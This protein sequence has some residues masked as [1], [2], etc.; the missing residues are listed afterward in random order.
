MSKVDST[1]FS[2]FDNDECPRFTPFDERSQELSE[3]Q[4]QNNARKKLGFESLFDT[5][6]P[7]VGEVDDVIGLC[8]GQFLT[9]KPIVDTQQTQGPEAPDSSQIGVESTPD[10]IVMT[11]LQS[12][13]SQMLS[14]TDFQS[15][16]ATNPAGTKVGEYRVEA[17]GS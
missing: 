3:K 4:S 9:Q 6:D 7:C 5:S 2:T 11:Q 1:P 17:S 8:S 10:T 13:Q 16:S 12:S 15:S 14:Q